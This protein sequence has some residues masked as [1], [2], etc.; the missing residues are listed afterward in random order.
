MSYFALIE[1]GLVTNVISADQEF[2][3]T[4]QGVWLQTSYNTKGNVHYGPDGKPDGKPAL[5]A[6][7]AGI[8]YTY[9]DVN[10]V[11]Y[12]PQ[13]YAS[14]TLDISTWLWQ[15]PVPY[16]SDNKNYIWDEPTQSWV[17]IPGWD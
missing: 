1:N 11:F 10:N 8:G 15:S 3:D 14:W 9:D 7:F 17:L 4:L 13:P 2:V 12:A 16:P 5:R 6:N